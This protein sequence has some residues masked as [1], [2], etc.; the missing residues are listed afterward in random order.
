M[1]YERINEHYERMILNH[2]DLA[3]TTISGKYI[4]INDTEV[5]L[6]KLHQICT[7][8]PEHPLLKNI[9][10]ILVYG[11]NRKTPF[12]LLTLID[13]YQ[14]YLKDDF[15]I[16][17]TKEYTY[18]KFSIFSKKYNYLVFSFIDN[19]T[20]EPE[21]KS[22]IEEFIYKEIKL[23][24]FVIKQIESDFK[25]SFLNGYD[26]DLSK[27]T[28]NLTLFSNNKN[29]YMG[30][31]TNTESGKQIVIHPIQLNEQ[32]GDVFFAGKFENFLRI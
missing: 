10:T 22:K 17:I 32:T 26:I 9:E 25:E 16:D 11:K 21:I 2:Y 6:I 8:L 19:H 20:N 23:P 29:D 5:G 3:E 14:D 28:F 24:D 4:T 1:R 18:Y 7:S 27:Y 13:E 31:F 12:N 15:F 30:I